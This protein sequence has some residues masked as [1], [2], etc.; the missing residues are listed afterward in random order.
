MKLRGLE[1]AGLKIM[2]QV[3]MQVDSHEL[4]QEYLS[5]KKGGPSPGIVIWQRQA[6]GFSSGPKEEKL[7]AGFFLTTPSLFCVITGKG[8]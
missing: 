1:E 2:E 5:T 7:L 6:G 8:F 4:T 3:S